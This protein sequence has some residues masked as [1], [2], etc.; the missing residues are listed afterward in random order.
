MKKSRKQKRSQKYQ[1][2]HRNIKRLYVHL[3]EE[4][5]NRESPVG[6]APEQVC[7][8]YRLESHI[9]AFNSAMSTKRDTFL[10]SSA[11]DLHSITDISLFRNY[12]NLAQHIENPNFAEVVSRTVRAAEQYVDFLEGLLSRPDVHIIQEVTKEKAEVT[13]IVKRDTRLKIKSK[14]ARADYI[15]PLKR[16]K[17]ALEK[18]TARTVKEGF[19]ESPLS[20]RIYNLLQTNP[21]AHSDPLSNT[22]KQVIAIPLSRGFYD[23]RDKTIIANDGGIAGTLASL[24]TTLRQRPSALF[25]QDI[26]EN[27]RGF[28]ARVLKYHRYDGQGLVNKT[29]FN[30]HTFLQNRK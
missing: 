23:G 17:A 2:L 29:R 24:S 22:D 5:G 30:A 3:F 28:S 4:R 27:P 9:A 13:R 18:N 15:A 6:L 8:E 16:M 7:C 11:I 14:K 1:Q 25:L 19:V 20:K 26:I 21:N 10:D 12:I